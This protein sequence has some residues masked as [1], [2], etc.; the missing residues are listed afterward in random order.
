MTTGE[1]MT[2]EAAVVAVDITATGE[3][4]EATMTG[5]SRGATA[6][7]PAILVTNVAEM[8]RRLWT[9]RSNSSCA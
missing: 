1:V 3:V 7:S 9:P 8:S 6:T 2:V 5:S 4:A